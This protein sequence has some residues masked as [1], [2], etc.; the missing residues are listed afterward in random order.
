MGTWSHVTGW[1]A[2]QICGDP[3]WSKH[4]KTMKFRLAL[5]AWN[6]TI[7]VERKLSTHWCSHVWPIPDECANILVYNI[8]LSIYLSPPQKNGVIIY[9]QV[10][11][12]LSFIDHK[13]IMIQEPP[14][15]RL[16]GEAHVSVLQ[17]TLNEWKAHLEAPCSRWPWERDDVDRDLMGIPSDKHTKTME[18]CHL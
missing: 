12:M 4:V 6:H 3:K 14:F 11:C 8:N 5:P 1:R 2:V 16:L 10:Y 18:N 13:S 9:G 7:Y 15:C 17:R